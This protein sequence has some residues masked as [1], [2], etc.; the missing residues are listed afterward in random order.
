[1]SDRSLIVIY[2]GSIWYDA[3][4]RP[5]FE[6][7]QQSFEHVAA[8]TMS[9][10]DKDGGWHDI[11]FIAGDVDVLDVD[12][13]WWR[14]ANLEQGN[15]MYSERMHA[16]I[17]SPSWTLSCLLGLI[18]PATPDLRKAWQRDPNRGDP[19]LCL[20]RGVGAG[21]SLTY[22]DSLQ[23][24]QVL[25]TGGTSLQSYKIVEKKSIRMLY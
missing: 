9:E 13:T 14:Q 10:Q 17:L 12:F 5:T 24:Q 3:H 7:L 11:S 4:L 23:E 16:A 19:Q 21:T 1:M 2:S 6:E 25:A 15:V 18:V 8:L 20:K 22:K